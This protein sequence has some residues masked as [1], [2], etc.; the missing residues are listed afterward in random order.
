MQ[1]G[2]TTSMQPSVQMYSSVH[3]VVLLSCAYAKT[4]VQK[5]EFRQANAKT[6]SWRRQE[7]IGSSACAS[8]SLL[9]QKY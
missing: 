3:N 7:A 5:R 1:G 8:V 6:I 4:Q 2:H 9:R